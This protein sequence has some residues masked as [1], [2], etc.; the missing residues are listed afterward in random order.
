MKKLTL[1]FLLITTSLIFPQTKYLI[2]FKDKGITPGKAL[3]KTEAVY[4][5]ALKL[6]SARSIERREKVMGKNIITYQDIPIKQDYV[7][8]IENLGVKVENELNW[9]NAISAFLTDAQVKEISAL[10]FVKNIDPVR[11]LS[12][13]NSNSLEKIIPQ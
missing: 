10:S 9:F 4:Q 3:Y 7:T 5:S 13:K 11:I 1:Y 12:F 2:Y 6:L 8:A